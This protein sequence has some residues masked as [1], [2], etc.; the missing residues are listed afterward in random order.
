MLVGQPL[1]SYHVADP[2]VPKTFRVNGYACCVEHVA[3]IVAQ[4]ARR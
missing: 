1:G 3:R 4:A 2:V